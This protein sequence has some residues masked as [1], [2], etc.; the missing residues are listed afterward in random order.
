MR[1]VVLVEQGPGEH[2][3]DNVTFKFVESGVDLAVIQLFTALTNTS[4]H[5]GLGVE[6]RIN[7]KNIEG[8]TWCG[9][10]I[11]STDDIAVTDEE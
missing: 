2:L 4:E 10:I 11:S 8:D 7:S 9:T 5:Q 3:R 6:R 1:T